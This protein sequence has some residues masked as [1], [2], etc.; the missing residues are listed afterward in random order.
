MTKAND[1]QMAALAKNPA[2]YDSMIKVALQ[3]M[4]ADQLPESRAVECSGGSDQ[5][6]AMLQKGLH[7]SQGGEHEPYSVCLI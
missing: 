1:D 5:D 4:I 2:A 6:P 3:A 7:R